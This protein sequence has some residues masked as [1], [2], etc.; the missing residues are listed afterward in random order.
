MD[1]RPS[2]ARSFVLAALTVASSACTVVLPVV[3]VRAGRERATVRPP[4]PTTIGTQPGLLSPI[5]YTRCIRQADAI[6]AEAAATA[7]LAARARLLATVPAC[8]GGGPAERSHH[9]YG[10]RA[11]GLA[12]L[13]LVLGVVTDIALVYV[14]THRA[15][16]L[17]PTAAA[18]RPAPH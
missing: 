4:A 12:S 11:L 8:R 17:E 18:A 2:A 1:A 14:I 3:G 13:G 15:A 7:D 9:R 10:E 5:E 6:T 16:D